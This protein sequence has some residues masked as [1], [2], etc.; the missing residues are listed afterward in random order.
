MGDSGYWIT[1]GVLSS[2]ECAA[3][4]AALAGGDRA[5]T[6]AGARNLMRIPEIAALAADERLL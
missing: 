6:R 1:E 3:L 4:S 5:R 2:R